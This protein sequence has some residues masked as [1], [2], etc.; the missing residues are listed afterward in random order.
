MS[1]FLA[2]RT[3]ERQPSTENE[4]IESG[5]SSGEAMLEITQQKAQ[6]ETSGEQAKSSQIVL[7]E[8]EEGQKEGVRSIREVE[9]P[10]SAESLATAIVDLCTEEGAKKQARK[11]LYT[12]PEESSN[13]SQDLYT[14]ATNISHSSLQSRQEILRDASNISLKR[15]L[16]LDTGEDREL[17]LLMDRTDVSL[18]SDD[19]LSKPSR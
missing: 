12:L 11:N 17:D 16:I 18:P 6:T 14:S 13:E 10:T 3:E 4:C 9:E 5:P 19:E 8:E 2:G 15:K 7:N 1:H